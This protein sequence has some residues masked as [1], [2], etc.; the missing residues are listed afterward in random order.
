M[1]F[2]SAIMTQASGSV[3]GLT[4]SRNRG[5][6]YF[7]GRAIPVNPATAAQQA[8]RAA[9]TAATTRWQQTLTQGQRDAWQTYADNVLLPDA[10]GEPRNVGGLG[11]YVRGNV[12]RQR[13]GLAFVD[14]GPTTFSLPTFTPVTITVDA[15]AV[16][17]DVN[18]TF[19]NTDAW[20][21]EDDAAMLIQASREQAPSINFFKGPF[22]YNE[23]IA[24]D[25]VTAPTSPYG[26]SSPFGGTAGNRVF[27]RFTVVTADGRLS[28]EQITSAIVAP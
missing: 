28:G 10:L 4:A 14:D 22:R 26:A 18:V 27:C 2:K 12:A 11:M 21:N 8:V 1:K 25:S 5:G 13:A 24:G 20:A 17:A 9:L 6:M 23:P 19:D 7:R 3:G 15:D 16:T